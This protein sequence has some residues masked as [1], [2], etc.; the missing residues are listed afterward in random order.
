[1]AGFFSEPI[2]C[3]CWPAVFL[4][5]TVRTKDAHHNADKRNTG[6]D[7]DVENSMGLGLTVGEAHHVL[8]T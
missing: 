3:G 8:G 6:K 1:M 2:S 4:G 7:I 5:A